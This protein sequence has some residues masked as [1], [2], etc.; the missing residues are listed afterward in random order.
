M[1]FIPRIN[2]VSA[3]RLGLGVMYVYSGYD[4]IFNPQHWY[5]F[6]PQWFSRAMVPNVLPAIETYLRVQ[7]AVEFLLG[8]AFLVWFMPRHLVR[9]AAVLA[10]LEMALIL[11]F[12]GVDPITFRDIGLLGAAIA[13]L[14][15][16]HR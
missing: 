16:L 13:L 10:A 6:V 9:L 3:L 1:P 5:G 8:L 2:P 12:I 11:I 15:V 4:L 14:A 7:G